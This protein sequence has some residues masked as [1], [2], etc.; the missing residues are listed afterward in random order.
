M[1]VAG[2]IIDSWKLGIF[3]K[4]LKEAGYTY[5]THPGI[6]KDTLILKVEYAWASELKPVVDAAN[7]EC[8]NVGKQR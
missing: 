2:V 3:E 7:K 6:A 5:T 8:A 1:K 4:H